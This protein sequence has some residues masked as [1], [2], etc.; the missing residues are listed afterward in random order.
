[1][2]ERFFETSVGQSLVRGPVDAR[3][4]Y[5]AIGP[6]GQEILGGSIEKEISVPPVGIE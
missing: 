2:L 6:D 4:A 1:M 5:G 3:E